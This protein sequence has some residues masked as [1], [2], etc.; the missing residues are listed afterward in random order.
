MPLFPNKLMNSLNNSQ[1]G[2]ST[3]IPPFNPNAI[4]SQIYSKEKKDVI[5]KVNNEDKNKVYIIYYNI[6]D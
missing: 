4:S 5:N 6:V 2:G 3:F 1:K